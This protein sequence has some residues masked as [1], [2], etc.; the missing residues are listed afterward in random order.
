MEGAPGYMTQGKLLQRL[1]PILSA[2]SD[3]FRIR[4]Y[5]DVRNPINNRVEA[6]AYAEAIVQR[7][8]EYVDP[9]D[10]AETPIDQLSSGANRNLGRQFRII[11]F[12][13]LDPRDI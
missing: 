12:Q 7:M 1:G 6:R 11:H 8:P 5:G 13:W 10:A 2:R 4:A 3:T 9:A